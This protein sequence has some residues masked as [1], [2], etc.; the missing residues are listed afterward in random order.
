VKN[1]QK[2]EQQEKTDW[3]ASGNNSAERRNPNEQ[4]KQMINTFNF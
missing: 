2:I 4:K 3:L 1:K